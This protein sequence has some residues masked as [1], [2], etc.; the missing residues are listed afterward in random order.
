M[1][2]RR[3]TGD[4]PDANKLSLETR[5]TAER[6]IL[7][8]VLLST[9]PVIVN[10]R[11]LEHTPRIATSPS[12]TRRGLERRLVRHRGA[13]SVGGRSATVFCRNSQHRG[14]MMNARNFY[15]AL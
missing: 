10:G 13:P 6:R 9:S 2:K 15:I 1:R 4:H 5:R 14:A 8:E 11:K 7:V 3:D 12:R